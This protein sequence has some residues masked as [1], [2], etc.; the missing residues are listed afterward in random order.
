MKRDFF[1]KLQEFKHDDQV[2]C[3]LVKSTSSRAFCAGGDIREIIETANLDKDEYQLIYDIASLRKPYI[4]LLNGITMG[5]GAGISMHG[6][7][8]VATEKT[9][10]A[11]PETAIGFI[12]DV[13]FYNFSKGLSDNIGLYMGLTGHR[14]KSKDVKRLGIATHFVHESDLSKLEND[15]Y[16]SSNILGELEGILSKYDQV[17]EGKYETE[18]IHKHFNETNLKKIFEN[19][20]TDGSDWCKEQLKI[21]NRMSPTAMMIN[22]KLFEMEQKLN[23]AQ[24]I[25]LEYQIGTRAL[26]G[27]ASRDFTEGVRA[28]L[29]DKGDTP[30]WSPANYEDVSENRVI[31]E[32]FKKREG[33]DEL[34]L[35]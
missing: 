6:K 29:I 5:A 16:A 34:G 21:L 7:Y 15:L 3:I 22:L 32:Y 17:C 14:L 31:E 11:M 13:G 2:K 19:L 12:A 26:T 18:K 10:F 23:L 33:D 8:R 27:T 4:S 25:N 30:K 28:V 1:S 35:V 20:K 24:S 9:V